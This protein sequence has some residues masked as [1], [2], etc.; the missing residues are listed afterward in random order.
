MSLPLILA[1]LWVVAASVTAFLPMRYQIAPGLLLLISAPVLIY[2]LA[3][4]HGPV[5][6]LIG[7]F[8]V[9]SMFRRPL[10]H[11]FRKLA[12]IPTEKPGE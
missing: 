11:L 5:I 1:C 4:E 7:I 8:A 6:T 9:L 10:I 12:G 3:R 2:F